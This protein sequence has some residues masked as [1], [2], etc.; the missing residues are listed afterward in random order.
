M[1][2]TRGQ[3]KWLDKASYT[4]IVCVFSAGFDQLNN[5]S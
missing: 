5:A 2:L 3:E 1:H 4:T